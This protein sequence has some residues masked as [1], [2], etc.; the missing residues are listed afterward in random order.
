M[1]TF[2]LSF[3]VACIADRKVYE[4]A[5]MDFLQTDKAGEGRKFKMDIHSMSVTLRTLADCV[6]SLVEDAK[7]EITRAI[8]YE[9]RQ[10]E[11]WLEEVE[12]CKSFKGI[13]GKLMSDLNQKE[14][15]TTHQ[16][17]EY[18]KK[19]DPDDADTDEEGDLDQPVAL[20]VTCNYQIVYT[21]GYASQERTETFLLTSDGKKVMGKDTTQ[22]PHE[23]RL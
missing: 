10:L 6:Q 9:T 15:S 23:T 7:E 13:A 1:E 3:I 4:Q 20:S 11:Y 12:R 21:D 17:I 22:L 18:L 14:L 5:I 2:A 16:R 8:A 19:L